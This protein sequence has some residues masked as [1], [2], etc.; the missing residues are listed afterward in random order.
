MS[1][2]RFYRTCVYEFQGSG[3]FQEKETG[4]L[5]FPHRLL[6]SE[7]G[8]RP[9][10]VFKR[11]PEN[12]CKRLIDTLATAARFQTVT[13]SGKIFKMPSETQFDSI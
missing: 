12:S 1:I 7:S 4:F 8:I 10:R 9:L 11:W 13:V 3:S 5:H 6:A 2:Y